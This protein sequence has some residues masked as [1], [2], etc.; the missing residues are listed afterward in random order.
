M[1]VPTAFRQDDLTIQHEAIR[2]CRLAI[3]VDA[4]EAGLQASHIPVLLDAEAGPYGTLLGHFA[5][6]NP[7]ARLQA[8]QTETLVVFPGPDAYVSPGWYPSKQATGK[9]VPTWN[10]VAVHAYGRLEPIDEP[11]AKRAIVA[12]LSDR[13]EAGQPHPWRIEDAPDDFIAAQL[14]AIVAFRMPISRLEGKWKLSQNRP[15]EDQA[16]VATAL[17]AA[18]SPPE[19][20]VAAYMNGRPR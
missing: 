17:A 6:S 18:G 10:Y 2:R 12:A 11:A 9:A 13:H 8:S 7:Q 3:L 20:T 19:T 1:Y 15:P 14:A 5:R 16:A 4:G